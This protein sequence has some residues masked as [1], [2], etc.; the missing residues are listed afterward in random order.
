MRSHRKRFG[1]DT[2]G[3]KGKDGHGDPDGDT[4]ETRMNVDTNVIHGKHFVIPLYGGGGKI[5]NKD[6]YGKKEGRASA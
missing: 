2:D 3:G 1:Q 5:R 4:G 6:G